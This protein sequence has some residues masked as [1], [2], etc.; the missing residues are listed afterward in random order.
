MPFPDQPSDLPLLFSFPPVF[1]NCTTIM[2]S[3]PVVR[4]FLFEEGPDG[5]KVPR[6]SLVC[7]VQDLLAL[8]RGIEQ[9]EQK[10]KLEVA[11][12][13]LRPN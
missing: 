5:I 7:A 3:G 11:A 8:G 1:F 10:M 13:G 2:V 9:V 4:I 12:S 6:A